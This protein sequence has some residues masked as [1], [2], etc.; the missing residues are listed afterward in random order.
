MF[1]IAIVRYVR[2]WSTTNWRFEVWLH[3]ALKNKIIRC[4]KLATIVSGRKNLIRSFIRR[5]QV[6]TSAEIYVAVKIL[7]T[8]LKR[9]I[10]LIN[11]KSFY[12]IDSFTF[13]QKELEKRRSNRFAKERICNQIALTHLVLHRFRGNCFAKLEKNCYYSY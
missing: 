8:T 5:K 12:F 7:L 1:I 6:S 4:T 2:Q 11:R 13:Q 3:I 10:I 9:S